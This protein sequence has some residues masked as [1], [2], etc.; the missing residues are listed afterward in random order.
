MNTYDL[1]DLRYNTIRI[2]Y[3]PKIYLIVFGQP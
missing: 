3:A 2:Y 1:V